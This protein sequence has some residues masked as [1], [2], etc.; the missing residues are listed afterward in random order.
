[1]AVSRH[2]HLGVVSNRLIIDPQLVCFVANLPTSRKYMIAS[3]K[4]IGHCGGC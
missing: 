2:F 3:V 1:M 4:I